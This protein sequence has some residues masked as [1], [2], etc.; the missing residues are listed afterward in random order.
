MPLLQLAAPS[1]TE[2]ST[3]GHTP[4]TAALVQSN[5]HHITGLNQKYQ[6]DRACIYIPIYKSWPTNCDL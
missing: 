6:T 4:A 1:L 3:P 2:I 5:S